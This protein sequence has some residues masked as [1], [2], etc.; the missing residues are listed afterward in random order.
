M[1]LQFLMIMGR[2]VAIEAIEAIEYVSNV[3]QDRDWLVGLGR[4]CVGYFFTAQFG[5]R[6]MWA[7]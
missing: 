5:P 1:E 6:L 7:G 3:M 2:F 4:S